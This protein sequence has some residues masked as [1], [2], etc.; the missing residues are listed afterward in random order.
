[1]R[2]N[3]LAQSLRFRWNAKFLPPS[4]HC[5]IHFF[6]PF[7]SMAKLTDEHRRALRIMARH[8]H[9]CAEALLLSQGFKLDL[10]GDLVFGGLALA[11]PQDAPTSVH[12]KMIVWMTITAAGRE[13]IA[14]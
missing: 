14:G 8:P 10:L 4:V 7:Q 3:D 2:G 11:T 5:S 1:L 6:F 13:A 12:Q 9:G